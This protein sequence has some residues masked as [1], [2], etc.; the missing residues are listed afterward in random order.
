VGRI[1]PTAGRVVSGLSRFL[2]FEADPVAQA[3]AQQAYAQQAA[4]QQ[5]QQLAPQGFFGDMLGGL[6]G[7]LVGRI[8]PTAGRV[9]SGL[10]RFLPFE[11]DPVAQAYAQ[12][13]YAQQAMQ[14][15]QQ[16]AP[17][18]FFGDMLGGIAGNLVGRINPTAG[19]VVN[20]LSRFLPFEA[21]PIAQAY[22]QQAAMQQQ[23]LAQA[24]AQQQQQPQQLAPQ[25]F[26]GDLISGVGGN[27]VGRINPTAGRVVSGLGRLLPFQAGPAYGYGQG[28]Y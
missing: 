11:A 25:G 18:G 6:A 12:Q 1:N 9:V 14:Q 17:Q 28:M 27:L 3:Y 23:Q 8:N 5:Q 7:N 22:A 2:P 4:Q 10:S 24:Y 21:D 19:R 15:Q 13:A 16:L 26:F 20:G